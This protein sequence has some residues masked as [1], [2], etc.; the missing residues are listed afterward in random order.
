MPFG[1]VPVGNTS[2]PQCSP[3]YTTGLNHF[4]L[5]ALVVEYYTTAA[6]AKA[7]IPDVLE[8]DDEPL[9]R[10]SV[11][12]YSM[13][14]VGHY[15]EYVHQIEVKWKGKKYNYCVTLIL[16][17]ESAIFSGRETWG[18]P[19]VFGTVDMKI[20]TA[21]A[22]IMSTIERPKGQHI[23]QVG[24]TPLS[25]H[26]GPRPEGDRPE[27]LTLR[28]IPSPVD[29]SAPDVKQLV[30]TEFAITGGD[31]WKGKG[32]VSFPIAS[33]YNPFHKLPVVK[34]ANAFYLDNA[35]AVLHLKETW[36]L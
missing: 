26:T 1:E 19:K 11:F 8:I 22:H 35:D 14:T 13:S 6:A 17:N 25:K 16:D 18:F 24:F 36:K 31:L 3:P 20:Q 7:V 15:K 4:K 33:E 27:S 32:S 2:I 5:S 28:V 29:G 10:S 12:N 9:C 23:V 34:Y 30:S 21:S